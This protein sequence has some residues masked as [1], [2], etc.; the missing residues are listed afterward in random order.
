VCATN[1]HLLDHV[2]TKQFRQ[3]LYYRLAVFPLSI[4]PLRERTED[5]A[6]LSAHFLAHF[7]SDNS[8]PCKYLT[9]SALELLQRAKWE[10]NVRE[11][12]HALERAFILAGNEAT[13]SVEHFRPFGENTHLREI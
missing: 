4:P 12:Q 5:V 8:V 6:A 1:L 3:D 7:S 9:P 11:L 13:L 2:Q 10:G